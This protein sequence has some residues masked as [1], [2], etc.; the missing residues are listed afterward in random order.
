MALLRLK[1]RARCAAR[2]GRLA[3]P[4]GW[5]RRM[6]GFLCKISCRLEE[7]DLIPECR[8]CA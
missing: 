5:L 8:A 6:A 3:L 2:R 1:N 7:T 4:L